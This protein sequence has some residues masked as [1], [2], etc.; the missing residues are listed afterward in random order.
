MNYT[1]IKHNV[2]ND[3]PILKQLA[4]NLHNK[5][6]KATLIDLSSESKIDDLP[7]H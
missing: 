6:N 7:F 4:N 1:I 3:L 2:D 5:S